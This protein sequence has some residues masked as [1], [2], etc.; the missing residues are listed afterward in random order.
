MTA[1]D[2]WPIARGRPRPPAPFT[3]LTAGPA[4]LVLDGGDVRYYRVGG[5]EILRRVY[6]AVRNEEWETLPAEISGVQVARAADGSAQAT[7]Q[8]KAAAGPIEFSWTGIIELGASGG[9]SYRMDGSAGTRFGYARIG[10]NILHPPS[11]AGRAYRAVTADGELAGVFPGGIGPQPFT[12][13]E[14][15]P[16]LP[17][18]RALHVVLDEADEV[19]V[20]LDGDE[21]EIEDQRN[22][23]DNSYK[24]YSTPMS[25]GLRRAEPGDTLS[26]QVRV[27]LSGR[28]GAARPGVMP[29]AAAQRGAGNH[30]QPGADVRL[31]VAAGRADGVFPALG[32][33]LAPP[34]LPLAPAQARL[35]SALHLSHLRADLRLRD[36]DPEATVAAAAAAARACGCGLELAVF[37]DTGSRGERAGLQQALR[38]RA[39]LI[40]RLLAF[41]EHELVTSPGVVAA[42]REA[43]GGTAVTY[44]GTNLYFAE[45]NRDRPDPAAADGFAFSANPQ[46][47]A[48]DDRSMTEAPLSFADM[49]ATARSFLGDRPLAVTP[50]TLLARFNADAPG[51]GT[52]GDGTPPPADHRQASLL[53]AAF[54]AL[55]AKYLAAG[56]AASAT[57]YETAGDRG[58]VAGETAPAGVPPGAAYPVCEVLA[59][60]GAWSGRPQLAVASSDPLAVAGLGC[61]AGGRAHV[62]VVN[63]TA[64]E[65]R[66]DVTGLAPGPMT[67]RMLDAPAV[68]DWWASGDAAGPLAAPGSAAGS[69]VMVLGPYAL[70][71]IDAAGPV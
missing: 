9:L 66:V 14:Y 70:A 23:L 3:E 50:V 40:R 11:L 60:L 65:L 71:L 21:F 1:A 68:G 69:G 6:V 13:G 37:I 5:R 49:L 32:L 48:A 54:T 57:F 20:E 44:G 34:G 45:L 51:A 39:G 24:T 64:R 22:W 7:Y 29:G 62:L 43:A 58:V 10:L 67:V 19:H 12:D 35:L 28:A 63:A 36:G 55:S 27:R 47:H 56:G 17:A 4:S 30:G 15:Y 46:V 16:L 61:A 2:L 41:S 18:F 38:G 8:A 53:C 33:G 25:L 52:A 59:V 26:Q 42:V 31:S